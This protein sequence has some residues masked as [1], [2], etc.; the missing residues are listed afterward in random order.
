MELNKQKWIKKDI[1][2]FNNYLY[3]LKNIEKAKCTQNIYATKKD[4][5]AIKVP[6][7][8]LMAKDIC[9][10]NAV[11]FLNLKTHKFIE[12]D[13][14]TACIISLIKDYEL[15]KSL[16]IDFLENVDSWVC[17]DT[18]KLNNKKEKWEDIYAFSC[19]LLNSK[20]PYLRRF[21]F[22]QLLKFAKNKE[23]IQDIFNLIKNA[24]YEQEY[25]VNMSI[26]WLI[27]EIMIYYPENTLKF[28]KKYKE[29]Y[30]DLNNIFVLKKSISKCQDS[31]RISEENKKLL[32]NL[33]QW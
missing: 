11:D 7:L 12:D 5:L 21:A 9:K 31:Y 30:K 3:S 20:Y 18:L 13:I 24:R 10:G 33:L 4:C 1:K 14:L 27:C 2:D 16:T 6:V 26:S 17:T 32:K 25:Y 23:S 29:N 19:E 15:Q 8:R 22:V 28:L